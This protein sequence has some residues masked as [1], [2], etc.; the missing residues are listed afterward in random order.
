MSKIKGP[1]IFLAQCYGAES[2]FNSL[3][4]FTSWAKEVR[5]YS[6]GNRQ[7]VA[8]VAALAAPTR[9]LILDE[10]TSG[11]DPLMERVFTEEVAEGPAPWPSRWRS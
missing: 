6:K 8:L 11:L 2:S 10:P 1:G 9:L 7:K 5:T 3:S 4:G